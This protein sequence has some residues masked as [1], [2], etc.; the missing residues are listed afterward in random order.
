[1]LCKFA[2]SYTM[3]NELFVGYTMLSVVI[4]RKR[5]S[6]E[7]MA[8]WWQSPRKI[9]KPE[10][11]A[12]QRWAF[13]PR[14]NPDTRCNP[15]TPSSIDLPKWFLWFGW[16]LALHHG[17]SIAREWSSKFSKVVTVYKFII[18]FSSLLSILNFNF[19]CFPVPHTYEQN[20][21]STG[22][23]CLSADSMAGRWPLNRFGRLN[24]WSRAVTRRWG[25]PASLQ[26][27]HSFLNRRP[28]GMGRG[29]VTP[30]SVVEDGCTLMKIYFCLLDDTVFFPS[31]NSVERR[32]YCDLSTSETSSKKFVFSRKDF[33][34]LMISEKPINRRMAR[35]IYLHPQAL[36]WFDLHSTPLLIQLWQLWTRTQ[37]PW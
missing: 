33:R 30:N 25:L 35:G 23:N 15:V 3:Y 27:C 32:A 4:G 7:A 13:G 24:P 31:R 8:G 26:P 19:S 22:R 17:I 1:M 18:D 20:F 21:L 36:R 11:G 37:S 12:R 10:G 9:S 2:M 28:W 16:C 14:R 5:L 29:K 34:D 6:A